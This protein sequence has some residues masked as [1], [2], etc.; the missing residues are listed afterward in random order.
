[1]YE[2][3]HTQEEVAEMLGTTQKVIYKRMKLLGY[4]PR[5]AV[6]RNQIGEKNDNWKG[7]RVDRTDGYIYKKRVG[8]P[9]ATKSGDYVLEHILVVEE[10]IGRYLFDDEVVHHI[11][12]VK[13]ENRLENLY[14]TTQSEHMKMHNIK[15]AH[16]VTSNLDEF[17]ER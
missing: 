11:N 10:Y 14:L 5:V 15:V 13:N 16:L 17:K 2:L 12:G 8:H 6:K 7:G 1:L 4:K 9:R 3:G